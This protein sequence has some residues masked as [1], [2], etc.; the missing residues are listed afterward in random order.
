MRQY[1]KVIG[2]RKIVAN[3]EEFLSAQAEWLLELIKETNGSNQIYNG[4]K[5][6]VGWTIF[7]LIE[8][9]KLLEILAPN[10]DTNPFTETS[11]DLSV[12]L[13]VQLSQNHVLQKLNLDGEASLFQDKIIMPKGAIDFERVYLERSKNYNEGDSGWYLGPVEGEDE[14]PELVAYYI[15]QLLNLRPSL[16]KALAIP[17][18]YI[19]VFDNDNIEAVLDENDNNIWLEVHES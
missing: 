1:K 14:N 12:S 5:I 17:R 8:Q 19:V 2:N 4:M 16:L 9:N 10:Y 3:C 6:Q 18:G 13:S 15:Y 11:K 7:T